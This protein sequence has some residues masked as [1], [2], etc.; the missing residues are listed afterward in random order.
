MSFTVKEA[1]F[2]LGISATLVYALIRSRKI[3]HERHGLGRGTIRISE[4]ALNEYRQS[5]E[6]GTVE[7]PPAPTRRHG[8]LKHL[9][10][11]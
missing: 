10:L 6:L 2:E 5:R 3:R 8:Q 11:K 1:A 4:T 9:H 7:Q